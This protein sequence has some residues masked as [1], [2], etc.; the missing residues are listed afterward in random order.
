MLADLSSEQHTP[1]FPEI[2]VSKTIEIVESFI[3]K[4]LPPFGKA[5]KA[6]SQN[7]KYLNSKLVIHLNKGEGPFI[8]EKDV[9][10]LHTRREEDI[11]VYLKESPQIDELPFYVLEAKLLPT[12]ASTSRDQREYV[13]GSKNDGGIERFKK[14][15]HGFWI[16]RCGMVGYIEKNDFNFWHQKINEWIGGL[17]TNNP[18]PNLSWKEADK[19]QPI[20]IL[21]NTARCNSSH[22][23]NR[24]SKTVKLSHF[25]V[26]LG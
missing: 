26:I 1:D 5:F 22:E 18:D 17:I 7:E 3:C 10:K 24:T 19:L 20:K 9:A 13:I 4:N 2:P 16:N 12:P 21:T 23:I 14:E 25:W 6:R 15:L 11:G 8:F